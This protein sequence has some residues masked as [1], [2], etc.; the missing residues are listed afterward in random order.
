M[1]TSR[2]ATLAGTWYPGAAVELARLVDNYLDAGPPA[3]AD[4]ST[5]P[6]GRPLMGLAPHAGYAYS[7]PVAGRLFGAL[8]GHTVRRLMILAP[9]H[10][11]PL[12]RPALSGA[13]TYATPLGLV[14]VDTAAVGRLAAGGALV[15]D[16]HAHRQEHAVEIQL[17]LVQRCW[18]GRC[19]AIIPILVPH[20]DEDRRARAAAALA[21][22]RDTETF[23]LVSTDLTHYGA[24]YGYV[25]FTHDVPA[26]L[27]R[28]DSGALLRVLAG[29]GRALLEYGRHTGITM[30]GLEAAALALA[31]GLPDGFESALLGYARSGDR[32]GDYTMSVSYAAALLCSGPQIPDA[33]EET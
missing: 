29:D 32:N 19:P 30:C 16:D 22:E 3:G 6:A 18:P 10:R 5:L 26:S 20:L 31:C 23:L 7:G 1:E 13:A 15:V 2:P 4:T 12:D 21:A 27:E 24:A 9:N 25:P 8:R 28:L 14:P 17:P 11:V 33:P